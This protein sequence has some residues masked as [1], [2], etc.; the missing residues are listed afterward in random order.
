M[1]FRASV[2]HEVDL[3]DLGAQALESIR[4][5]SWAVADEIEGIANGAQQSP[6]LVAALNARTEVL[7]KR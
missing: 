7:G 4:T 1:L 2:G 3:D 5:F 6:H